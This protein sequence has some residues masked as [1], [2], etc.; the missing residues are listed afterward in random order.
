MYEDLEVSDNEE[1]DAI[2]KAGYTG[3][4]RR[5]E[6]DLTPITELQFMDIIRNNNKL[7]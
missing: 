5:N 3:N 1:D 4:F 2:D 7:V 6:K